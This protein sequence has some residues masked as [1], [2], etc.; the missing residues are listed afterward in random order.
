MILVIPD[1]KPSRT[2]F[3]AD[4]VY[5]SVPWSEYLFAITSNLMGKERGIMQKGEC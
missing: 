3:Y 4:V 2:L 5:S 1:F